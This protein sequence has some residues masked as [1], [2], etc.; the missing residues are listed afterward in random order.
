MSDFHAWL[1]HFGEEYTCEVQGLSAIDPYFTTLAELREVL[2][3]AF[4]LCLAREEV[5]A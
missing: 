2:A 4:S 1:L 3:E 5:R